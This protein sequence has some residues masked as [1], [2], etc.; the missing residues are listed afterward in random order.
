MTPVTF[1]PEEAEDREVFL[2]WALYE[3]TTLLNQYGDLADKL[4]KYLLTGS[5]SVGECVLL[6]EDELRA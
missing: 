2:R 1:I 4:K 6:I 5:T 3:A